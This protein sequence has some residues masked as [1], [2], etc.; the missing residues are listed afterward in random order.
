M[1]RR[2]LC[3][4][5]GTPHDL[6]RSGQPGAFLVYHPLQL[7]ERDQVAP[8]AF[9]PGLV[10]VL[11]QAVNL[12]DHPA[13]TCD[14]KHQPAKIRRAVLGPKLSQFGFGDRFKWWEYAGHAERLLLFGYTVL[15]CGV[16]IASTGDQAPFFGYYDERFAA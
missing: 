12:A 6:S 9:P 4:G 14:L 13:V 10:S 5:R 3:L 1:G 8:D 11:I 15:R 2:G 16:L 7:L